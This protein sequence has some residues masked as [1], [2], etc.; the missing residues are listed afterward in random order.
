[1]DIF[2][3]N[4]ATNKTIAKL[5]NDGI[6]ALTLIGADGKQYELTVNAS[7]DLAVTVKNTDTGGDKVITFATEAELIAAGVPV[8]DIRMGDMAYFV[9]DYVP[10]EE[11]A[12][13]MR[14]ETINYYGEPYIIEEW[15]IKQGGQPGTLD[16]YVLFI[17]GDNPDAEAG[18]V[19]VQTVETARSPAGI[20]I[21]LTRGGTITFPAV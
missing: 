18:V 21:S 15:T 17:Y 20:Y 1:M 5:K 16:G 8:V 11:E 6:E 7:G 10:T 4:V 2:S 12:L 19:Y 3:I 14:V 13:R 9:S